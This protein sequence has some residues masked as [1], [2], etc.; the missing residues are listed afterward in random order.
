MET[1]IHRR[2]IGYTIISRLEESL[3]QLVANK[4]GVLFG[5]FR[6]AIPPG[7]LE[8]TDDRAKSKI[9][10]VLDFLEHTDFPDLKE[11]AIYKGLYRYYFEHLKGVKSTLDP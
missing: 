1:S 4:I 5:D 7:I 10:D 6:E 2:D 9:D 3:R 11:I 8:K